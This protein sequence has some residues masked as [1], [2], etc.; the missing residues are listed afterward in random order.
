MHRG[1]LVQ[2]KATIFLNVAKRWNQLG[3]ANLDPIRCVTLVHHSIAAAICS[4]LL[5]SPENETGSHESGGVAGEGL[6]GK[7][8][9]VGLALVQG[10]LLVSGMV[11]ELALVLVEEWSNSVGYGVGDIDGNSRKGAFPRPV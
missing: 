8:T 11:L 2:T 3:P 6:G 10:S 7:G 9:G 4:K 5:P 1:Q